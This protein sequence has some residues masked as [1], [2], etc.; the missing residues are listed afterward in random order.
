MIGSLLLMYQKRF[1]K[2]RFTEMTSRKDKYNF[3]PAP[4]KRDKNNKAPR[5]LI[6]I[7]LSWSS[8]LD[9]S[10]EMWGPLVRAVCAEDDVWYLVLTQ[11]MIHRVY[12]C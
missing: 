4:S 12:T 1:S 9:E 3:L 11:A 8:T 7:R 2:N 5:G 6:E 10:D